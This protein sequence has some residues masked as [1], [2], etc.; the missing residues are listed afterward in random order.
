M[1]KFWRRWLPGPKHGLPQGVA[2]HGSRGFAKDERRL[3]DHLSDCR[4]LRAWARTHHLD[5]DDTP[6]SLAA[7]DEAITPLTGE[8]R[9]LLQMDGGLYLGTVLVDRRSLFLP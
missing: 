8:G 4:K 6:G 7:L 3:A 1:S 2:V 5:L 9:H